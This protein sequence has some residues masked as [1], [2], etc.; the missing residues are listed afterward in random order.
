MSRNI[1]WMLSLVP[2]IIGAMILATSLFTSAEPILRGY[3]KLISLS[4]IVQN[5]L[6]NSLEF[7]KYL[8]GPGG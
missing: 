7:M 2:T 8:V 4:T 5:F 3:L 6:K 1:E